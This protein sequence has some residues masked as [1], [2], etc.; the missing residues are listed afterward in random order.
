MHVR[1]SDIFYNMISEAKFKVLVARPGLHLNLNG[2][3]QDIPTMED[4]SSN[5]LIDPH[6][7]SPKTPPHH[8]VSSCDNKEN[9]S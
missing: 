5:L 2:S 9:W 4:L 3:G 1:Q 6:P 7:C 8:L